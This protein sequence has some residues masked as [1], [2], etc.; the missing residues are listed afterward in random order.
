MCAVCIS[1]P[2]SHSLENSGKILSWVKL[3]A[4]TPKGFNAHILLGGT[5]FWKECQMLV[6]AFSFPEKYLLLAHFQ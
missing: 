5:R 6:E 1:C 4:N 3:L 2:L